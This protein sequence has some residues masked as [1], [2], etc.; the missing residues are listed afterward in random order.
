MLLLESIVS[1]INSILWDYIL[2]VALVGTGIII[3]IRLGFPQIRHFTWGAKKVF[4][5]VFKKGENREGSMS[6]F[7]ALATAVAAQI[8]TGNIAGVATAITLGG[9]GAVFWMWVSAFFGMSTIFVE[10]TLAQ[11]Y[12]ETTKNGQLVGGPAYYI[13]NGLG[14]KSLAS[15]FAVSII[16]ALGFIGN[17]VQSN[18]I[19]DVVSRAFSI[20]Q[21]GIGVI[22]AFFAAL[23]FIGGMKRIASFTE[24]IVPIMAMIYIIGSILIL[25]LFRQNI[26]LTLKAI[27]IGAFSSKSILG[28]AAG[29]G[30]QQA[31]RYG[32]ARGL[33]SNE[34]GMGSTPNSH[35]VADVEHPAEQG[36]SA[37]IAV[38]IDT[39]LVCTAT[40]LIILTTGAQNLGAEGAGV[41]QEAFNLAFGPIGQ[42]F[43]AICLTFFAFT[44]IIG[45]YY[46]GENNIRFL[47]KG[48]K[49]IRIY[50]VIVL[51][52][53]ILGSFQKVDLV[54][55]LADMF[56][57][58]MVIPNLI[59]VLFL[60]K[61]S[62]AILK[63]Y[64]SQILR[65]E[66]LHYK[67]EYENNELKDYQK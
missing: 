63:D 55:S 1:T 15:F 8:G 7:Q 44:T 47:F 50:Q 23:I 31:I 11:K 3:S 66:K 12:R 59:G 35:A 45:W 64:D 9:P 52:F 36:L 4:G 6:S 57:G 41:T 37:M 14:S 62:K 26:I 60:F 24:T 42:K 28:G 27:F 17:M 65:G 25:I 53:I 32:V 54:W 20:P 21:L 5:G 58:I 61:E 19:A 43:L 10:A 40:T 16:L 38:C 46:F 49:A 48:K 51:I 2:I 29:V 33:F 22:I 39:M 13:K 30:M 56:N 34:A 67:Y 18:S